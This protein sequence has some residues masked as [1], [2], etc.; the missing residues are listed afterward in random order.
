MTATAP[1]GSRFTFR[2]DEE[3][4]RTRIMAARL[5]V[6]QANLL[7]HDIDPD[8]AAVAQRSLPEELPKAG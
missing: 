8:V 7:K 1:S 6:R 5:L 3:L 4:D 2:D